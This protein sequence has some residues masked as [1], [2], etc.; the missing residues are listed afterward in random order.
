[1]NYVVRP[2]VFLI[3]L[4]ATYYI[5]HTTY[6]AADT[7]S[8][9]DYIINGSVQTNPNIPNSPNTHMPEAP[10]YNPGY[11]IITDEAKTENPFVF[12]LSQTIVDFGPLSPT[13]PVL[14]TLDLSSAN[15]GMSIFAWEDTPLTSTT[16]AIIPD[17]TCDNGDCSEKTSAA[18]TSTLTYGFGYRC[19]G[20]GCVEGFTKK[21]A[22]RHFANAVNQAEL[23]PIVSATK[24]TKAT[25]TYRVNT[26]PTQQSGSYANTVTYIAAPTY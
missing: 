24:D 3:F 15:R 18:W 25:I 19:D 21:D 6:A 13:T 5:L 26:A 10:S 9:S 22:Y 16:N 2:K 14:R 12:S 7:M 4:L 20:I 17:T 11:K 8:S 23:K 1:M